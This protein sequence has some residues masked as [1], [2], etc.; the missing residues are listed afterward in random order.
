MV[1]QLRRRQFNAVQPFYRTGLEALRQDDLR[2]VLA[3]LARDLD[4]RATQVHL[5]AE[6]ESDVPAYN[7]R[8]SGRLD[9]LLDLRERLKDDRA[10]VITGVH[11]LGG[12]GKTE[13]A[14]TYAHA[15]A[16]AY[17]GGRFLVHCEGKTS[18]RDAALILGNRFRDRISDEERKS[19]D[20]HFAAIYDCLR[21]R[22]D[23][24]GRILLVLDN[25]TGLDLL[26]P[27]QTDA[28][29]SLGPSLHLLATTRLAPPAGAHGNWVT[30]GEL[31]EVDAVDLLEKH[32]PFA[33]DA[34]RDAA[35]RIVR[36]LG[37]FVLAVELVAAW[38]EVHAGVTYPAFLERLGLEDLEALDD[39][40]ADREVTLRQHD[41]ERRLDA[42]LGPSIEGLE[43]AGRRAMEYAALLAPDAVPLPWLR[44]LVASDFP[45]I[46]VSVSPGYEE[47]WDRICRMLWRLALIT[48]GEG[49]E[50]EA[51]VVR[52]HRLVQDLMQQS[53]SAD[54]LAAR[55]ERVLNFVRDRVVVLETTTRWQEARWELE[56]LDA[57]AEAWAEGAYPWAAWLLSQVGLWWYTLAEWTRAE[58]LL[59]RALAISESDLGEDQPVVATAISNLAQ[60][61]Q[62]TNRL[63]EAEPLM[64]RALAI[65]ERSSGS[66]HPSVAIRLNNLAGL[67]YATNRLAEA[68][69]LM[70]RALAIR[71]QGCGGDQHQVAMALNSLAQLLKAT[72]RLGEAEPLYRRSLAIFERIRGRDHPNVATALSNLALL[73][74]VTNRPAEAEDLMRR[75]LVI[76]E[77]R[78]GNDHPKVAIR[79][80]NLVGLLKGARRQGEAEPLVRRALAIFENRLGRDHPNVASALNNL[81]QL[82]QDTN[83]LV[84][85]EPLS[86]R[87]VSILLQF[88][89]ATGHPHP[90][91]QAA[92]MNYAALLRQM[93]MSRSEILDRLQELGPEVVSI[94]RQS[95]GGL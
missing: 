79:L 54:H 29:T 88:T 35:H 86:R 33:D 23:S 56:P 67:L 37:G 22:L 71:E 9:E 4:E 25:V 10:G 64:R 32:R 41:H 42:V 39:L 19:P 30:L 55:R 17:P 26:S 3:A 94:F 44:E 60:L 1:K 48:R 83:R 38:L 36:R 46:G 11:G 47:P 77:Q 52:V 53:L 24:H 20:R 87:H 81:A 12:I 90:N 62:A 65:D 69:P 45:E 15:F 51:R 58:P 18:L 93:D 40:A 21:Q 13:L 50:G 78:Y 72:G 63:A 95:T 14:F 76:D 75:A 84:E 43:P 89:R 27:R 5:A 61:L 68:E 91:L 2:C 66:D 49:E 85:A 16:G 59:R 31:P 70:R 57:L 8:F 34:E 28:L 6:S 74:Q 82:L 92:V 7:R 73:L 80:N